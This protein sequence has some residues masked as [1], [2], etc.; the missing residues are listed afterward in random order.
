MFD[1]RWET[2]FATIRRFSTTF[3]LDSHECTSPTHRETKISRGGVL[4]RTSVL[5]KRPE[6]TSEQLNYDHPQGEFRP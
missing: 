4:V 3:S 5:S 1:Y 2:M 6:D